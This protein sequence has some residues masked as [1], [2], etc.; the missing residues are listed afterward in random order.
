M[1]YVMNFPDRNIHA[2]QCKYT[3]QTKITPDPT[4]VRESVVRLG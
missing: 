2:E 3:E 1:I 4:T